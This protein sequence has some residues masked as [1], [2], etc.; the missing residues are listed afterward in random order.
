MKRDARDV[1]RPVVSVPA[2]SAATPKPA[3][4]SGTTPFFWKMDKEP[5]FCIIQSNGYGYCRLLHP[6]AN[7]I[8]KKL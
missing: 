3:G 5:T 2:A 6:H 7:E 1:G 8:F 4:Y